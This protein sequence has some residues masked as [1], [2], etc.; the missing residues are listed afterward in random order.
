MIDIDTIGFMVG[1]VVFGV[2]AY[3]CLMKAMV[4]I[5]DPVVFYSLF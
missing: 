1:A 3:S 5:V 2:A 4:N